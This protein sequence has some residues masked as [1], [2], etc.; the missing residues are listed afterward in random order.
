AGGDAVT[1]SSDTN[2]NSRRLPAV[3]DKDVP[4]Q[5]PGLTLVSDWGERGQIGKADVNATYG[6]PLGR[7]PE[8]R[9]MP[10]HRQRKV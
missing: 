2:L 4:H 5:S 7:G 10:T 8:S 6:G 1:N 9:A 3:G